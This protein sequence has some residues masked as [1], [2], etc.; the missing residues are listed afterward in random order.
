[1]L[2][3]FKSKAAPEVIMYKEHAKRIL[4]LFHKDLDR[5]VLTAAEMAGA[6]AKLEAEIADSR[7]HPVS[8]E[9]RH[10][11]DEHHNASGDDS[12]HEAAENVSFSTRAYPVLEMLRAAQRDAQDVVW[13]V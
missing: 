10:D 3:T 2:I 13:G 1:M 11:I 7:A 5:G 12:D 8:E 9:V 4:D 6:L